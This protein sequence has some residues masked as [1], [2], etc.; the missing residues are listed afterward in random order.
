MPVSVVGFILLFSVQPQLYALL[1][2]MVLFRSLNNGIN[3]PIRENLYIPTA[4]NVRFKSKSWID[5][6]GRMSARA[7][8]GIVNMASRI[9]IAMSPG[10]AFGSVITVAVAFVWSAVAFFVGKK[11][12]DVVKKGEVIGSEEST[13]TT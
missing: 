11:Y 12:A 2:I 9:P 10:I 4:R 1:V 5:S 3:A 13:E 6:F 7:S 8:G